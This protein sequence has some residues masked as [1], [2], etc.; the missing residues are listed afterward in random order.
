[1]EPEPEKE[2][3]SRFSKVFESEKFRSLEELNND[4]NKRMVAKMRPRVEVPQ[5]PQHDEPSKEVEKAPRT[6]PAAKEAVVPEQPIAG[7]LDT[8]AIKKI[9][10]GKGFGF[11]APDQDLG[12]GDVFFHFSDVA[13]AGARALGIGTQVRY[14]VEPDAASGR[15]RAK[16]VSLLSD[17]IPAP[18]P[19]RQES[20]EVACM[21]SSTGC[22]YGRDLM[23]GAWKKFMTSSRRSRRA[24]RFKLFTVPMPPSANADDEDPSLNDE[25]LLARLEAR[26]DKETGADALNMETFGT[27]VGWSF[28]EAVAANDK[29]RSVS[30]LSEATTGVGA[31]SEPADVE[32][33]EREEDMDATWSEERIGDATWSWEQASH[34]AKIFEGRRQSWEVVQKEK[35]LAAASVPVFQ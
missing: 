16:N 26:L 11:I 2:F 20:Q 18:Q 12:A 1:M 21:E 4:F 33:S 13:S 17:P 31:L 25:C 19:E 27:Y 34:N 14:N 24:P 5:K 22:V 29:L 35:L 9:F 3:K 15:L 23:L 8:G 30:E 7:A 6:T 10:E 32:V 28:E